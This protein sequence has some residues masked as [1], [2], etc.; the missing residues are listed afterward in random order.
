MV[1]NIEISGGYQGGSLSSTLSWFSKTEMNGYGV[2]TQFSKTLKFGQITVYNLTSSPF[3]ASYFIRSAAIL[4]PG[5]SSNLSVLW[6]LLKNWGSWRFYYS[7]ILPKVGTKGSLILELFPETMIIC[8]KMSK[9]WLWSLGR[10]FYPNLAT[11]QI[12]S[13]DL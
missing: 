12:R 6:W 7:K 4:L 2:Y 10:W 8:R 13:T 9:K 3:F 1:L 5:T 11:N